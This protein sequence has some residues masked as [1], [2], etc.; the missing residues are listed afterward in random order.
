MSTKKQFFQGMIDSLGRQFPDNALLCSAKV[1]DMNTWPEDES[2]RMLYG[3]REL[4]V[5][6]KL[7]DISC[8]EA[9]SDFR[10][11]KLTKKLVSP[12][13]KELQCRL[14]I[15]SISSAAYERGFSAMNAQHTSTR[16]RL[17]MKNLDGLLF[18]SINGM[19]LQYWN[20]KPYV[21]TRLKSGRRSAGDKSTGKGKK[22]LL[23]NMQP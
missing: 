3:D 1:L 20:P 19:P 7:V 22:K 10:E 13:I 21:I 15:I 5:L 11:Y 14:E 9:L 18:V 8:V 6:A 12:V 23:V 4:T 2:E 16:N 17:L